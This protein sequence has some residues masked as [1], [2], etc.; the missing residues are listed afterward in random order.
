MKPL[1]IAGLGEIAVANVDVTEMLQE[2][3][4]LTKIVRDNFL[5]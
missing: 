5:R 3:P 2:Y 1:V 4:E